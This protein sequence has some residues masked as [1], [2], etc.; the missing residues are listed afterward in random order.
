MVIKVVINQPLD[1]SDTPS[2]NSTPLAND[3]G[4]QSPVVSQANSVSIE[5]RVKERLSELTGELGPTLS[6]E[7]VVRF[8]AVRE[9]RILRD[10][11]R[12]LRHIDETS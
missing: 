5:G 9:Q 10:I 11:G 8:Q 6:L 1:G 12:R 4:S 2:L 3:E 7:E